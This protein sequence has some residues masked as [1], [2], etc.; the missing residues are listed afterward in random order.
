VVR[1][2]VI[3]TVRPRFDSAAPIDDMYAFCKI[4]FT[5][6]KLHLMFYV[7]LHFFSAFFSQKNQPTWVLSSEKAKEAD[8]KKEG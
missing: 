6:S 3:K 4:V 2:L 1:A 7:S 8:L 5:F